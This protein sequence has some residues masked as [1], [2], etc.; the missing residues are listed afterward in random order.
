M[1]GLAV[2]PTPDGIAESHEIGEIHSQGNIY[3]DAFVAG[4]EEE[5]HPYVCKTDPND[6]VRRIQWVATSS[7]LGPF[8]KKCSIWQ[9]LL[10]SAGAN[11]HDSGQELDKPPPK[12]GHSGL[13]S[14]AWDRLFGRNEAG[15]EEPQDRG[16]SQL[17]GLFNETE[18]SPVQPKYQEEYNSCPT[19]PESAIQL[20][21]LS[22]PRKKMAIEL[23]A[24][25]ESN[26]DGVEILETACPNWK[27][28]VAFAMKQVERGNVV[29]ALER[30]RKTRTM[31][32]E[33]K[34]RCLQKW[35]EETYVLEVFERGLVLSLDRLQDS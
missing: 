29:A 7:N 27:E 18:F 17:L 32:L 9:E 21:M 13:L 2:P 3:T 24:D 34:Q 6:Q 33:Q 31:L 10:S 23:I 15:P 16:L 8:Q 14:C 35:E 12:M 4:Q 5:Y 28:N 19:S 26:K 20:S 25:I 11:H 22:P 1:N 30:I